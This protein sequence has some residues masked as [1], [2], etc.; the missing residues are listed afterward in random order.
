[1]IK[2]LKFL[3]FSLIAIGFTLSVFLNTD[4]TNFFIQGFLLYFILQS[5]VQQFILHRYFC[6]SYFKVN[7]IT[8]NI[9]C[10]LSILAAVGPPRSYNFIHRIHHKFTDTKRDA[11]GP[12]LGFGTLFSAY[13]IENEL[14]K[15]E[16]VSESAPENFLNKNY[17]LVYVIFISLLYFISFYAFLLYMF[18]VGFLLLGT[19][20]FNYFAHHK[21]FPGNYRN[22]N[23]KDSSYNNVFLSLMASDWHNNH[24]GNPDS[25]NFKY[26]W[27]EIDIP[28]Y[29]LNLLK[30]LKIAK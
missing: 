10:F 24:H 3:Q 30:S 8:H 18:A 25:S 14:N 29:Y 5:F 6:H 11:H 20:I 21:L 1:M 22:F 19:E 15:K 28:H 17:Y 26:K 9:F 4:N 2:T 7:R 12:M 16:Y 13:N 27:W 23:S